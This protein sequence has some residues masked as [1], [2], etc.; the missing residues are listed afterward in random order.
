MALH[1]ASEAP[2]DTLGFISRA[3]L[4]YACTQLLERWQSTDGGDLNI[5]L[6]GE[7]RRCCSSCSITSLVSRF[8]EFHGR[9]F[10]EVSIG[11]R[12]TKPISPSHVL[13]VDFRLSRSR[14]RIPA[15][16]TQTSSKGLKRVMKPLSTTVQLHQQSNTTSSTP[17]ATASLSCTFSSM[18]FHQPSQW[19]A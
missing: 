4:R 8:W 11:H 16:Q 10:V 9:Q 2:E 6:R 18:I 14:I 15:N 12:K 3:D 7:V 1:I 19:E 5:K 17:P 13:C